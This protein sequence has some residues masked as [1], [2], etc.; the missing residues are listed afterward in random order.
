MPRCNRSDQCG[1]ARRGAIKQTSAGR[2]SKVA[3]L[4][5]AI[6]QCFG[7]GERLKSH[8]TPGVQFLGG[9]AYL[10][11]E[12]KLKTVG[13]AGGGIPIHHRRIDAAKE[14]LSGGIVFRG[15]GL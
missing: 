10:G 12:P 14:F 8:R 9:N 11:T 3:S 2:I 15:N 1:G 7:G 5:R 13:K 6:A 4:P